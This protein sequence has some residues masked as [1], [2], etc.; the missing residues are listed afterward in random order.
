MYPRGP[1]GRR[2]HARGAPK[3]SLLALALVAALAGSE[4]TTRATPPAPPPPPRAGGGI[5][6]VDGGR[7]VG[8]TTIENASHDGLTVI[9]L[10]DGWLPYIF[11]EEP[12][13]P[14]PLRPYLIDLENERFHGSATY[15]RA[16]E[17]RH[18]EAFGITPSLNLLRRRLADKKRHAC[19]ARVKDGVLEELSAK[20]V[21]PAEEP[22]KVPCVPPGAAGAP[23]APPV[24]GSPPA[25]PI[26]PPPAPGEAPVTMVYTGRTVSPRPL[27][28]TEKRAVV[29]MQ[30]HLR[31]EDLLPRKANA[32]R[33][34]RRTS[35]GLQI[36]QR[37]Q[38]VADNGH[39][40]LDTRTALL[41]DSREQDFRAL[42]RALRE[43]V[44]DATGLL[45]DGSALGVEG[46]V[47][48]RIL[49]TDEFG[50]VPAQPANSNAP[51]PAVDASAKIVAAPDLIAAATQAASQ[52]LGWT[53]PDAVLAST[54][55]AA[56][57]SKGR[58]HKAPRKGVIALPVAV[59]VRLP[60][61]PPYHSAKMELR[62]EI[63]R[64][65]VDLVRPKL[66]KDGHKKWKPPVADRPTLT[67]Y[68]RAGDHEVALAR[69]PTTIG[70]W[71]TF[72]KSDGTMALKYKE[73]I[74]GDALWPEVLATPTWHPAAGMPTRHLLIKHG[75]TFVAKTDIIGPGYHAAYGL[76]AIVHHQIMGRQPNGE[77]DLM[78]LR[79]RTHGTPV[80]RS[81]KRGESNG[82]HRLHNFEALRLAG[83]LLKH[84]ENV[85]DG[86]VPEDYV[87]N[88]EYK[89]Q[90]V[91]LESE[92][93]GYRFRLT[94]PVPVTVLDGDVKGNA[95]NVKH[96]VPL[97]E[98]P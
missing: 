27:T 73:S 92:T 32:A 36:Y 28:S 74:T 77:P 11:S 31:C 56:P 87:R 40:D 68:A 98:A 7:A 95:K 47:Q 69:W 89:G 52:A 29:A 48:G 80:Y 96:L 26:C 84:H 65:E 97:T 67:L 62:A 94:P 16:R 37:L 53:S 64:G 4:R 25:K 38:M 19:H 63:D 14:Q 49:D 85:R 55:V 86:L 90:K 17:D 58:A 8:A 2:S 42:L 81:V 78:D 24:P 3:A 60:P 23:A 82:C 66:D 34:D 70:G 91:A 57:V 88:I 20:N 51:A 93:K 45:E 21:I 71:K 41:G 72:E 43:R 59:A 39:I 10:S 1:A 46:Q 76:V 83:F 33:M 5:P 61:L 35:E 22:E 6:V 79:I 12:G 44:V 15:A 13:K 54:I 50:P 18:F 75:D 9:D 30:A